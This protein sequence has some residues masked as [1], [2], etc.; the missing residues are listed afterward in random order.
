M[1]EFL[2]LNWANVEYREDPSIRIAGWKAMQT[3]EDVISG[4]RPTHSEVKCIDL[5]QR[6]MD[7]LTWPTVNRH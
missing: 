3:A 4:P 7:S 6:E 2:F 1:L 5:R